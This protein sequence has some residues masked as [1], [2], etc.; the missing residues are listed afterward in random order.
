MV[1]VARLADEEGAPAY[2]VGLTLRTSSWL[3][4]TPTS[5]VL[6]FSLASADDR[7]K[8]LATLAGKWASS[9]S[10]S[11]AVHADAFCGIAKFPEPQPIAT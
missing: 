11:F 1:S 9:F 7:S 10:P 4:C 3:L 6:T 8:L 2:R 5:E